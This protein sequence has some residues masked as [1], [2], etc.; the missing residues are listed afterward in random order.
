MAQSL[1]NPVLAEQLL[2]VAVLSRNGAGGTRTH[3]LRFRKPST[4]AEPG[5]SLELS[6]GFWPM[7]AKAVQ[8]A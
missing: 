5:S 1:C 4:A 6:Q 8:T 3:D 7:L 2:A